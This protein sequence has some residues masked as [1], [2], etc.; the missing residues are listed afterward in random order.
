MAVRRTWR[1]GPHHQV[2]RTRRAALPRQVGPEHGH[3]GQEERLLREP[4]LYFCIKNIDLRQKNNN[5]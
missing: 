3:P 5:I 1:G 4:G 2:L